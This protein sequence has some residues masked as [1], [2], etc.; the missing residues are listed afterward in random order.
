MS[1]NASNNDIFWGRLS[2]QL[3][4]QQFL[5]AEDFIYESASFTTTMLIVTE[6]CKIISINIQIYNNSLRNTSGWSLSLF[7]TRVSRGDTD[8]CCVPVQVLPWV[9]SG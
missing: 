5:W 8:P 4:W 1:K 7:S 9:T 6:A 2:E 3:L